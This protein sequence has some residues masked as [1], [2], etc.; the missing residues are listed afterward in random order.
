MLNSNLQ[1]NLRFFWYTEHLFTF[2][3]KPVFSGKLFGKRHIRDTLTEHGK[4]LA[5]VYFARN[6]FLKI[7]KY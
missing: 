7:L 6:I 1:K 2:R 5:N 4:N 3:G